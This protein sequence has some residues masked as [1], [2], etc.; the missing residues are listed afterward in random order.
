MCIRLHALDERCQRWNSQG[1]YVNIKFTNVTTSRVTWQRL[2]S[3]LVGDTILHFLVVL[4]THLYKHK[5]LKSLFTL[6]SGGPV[7]LPY[8]L[9][10]WQTLDSVE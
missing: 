6:R 9:A 4:L 3:M 1:L 7:L 8:L 5:V 10:H 2:K